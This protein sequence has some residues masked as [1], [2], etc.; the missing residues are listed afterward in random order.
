MNMAQMEDFVGFGFTVKSQYTPNKNNNKKFFSGN[1]H[2]FAVYCDKTTGLTTY[3]SIINK[4]YYDFTSFNNQYNRLQNSGQFKQYPTDIT[5]RPELNV[6]EIKE[7][8]FGL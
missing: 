3:D 7:I 6:E 5:G 2:R 1:I 8:R 4:N